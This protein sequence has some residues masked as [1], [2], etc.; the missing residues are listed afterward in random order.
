[1]KARVLI[2]DDSPTVRSTLEWLL[3]D[4]GYMVAVAQD[5]LEALVLLRDYRPELVLLDIFLPFV[6]GIQICHFIRQ[7]PE[8]ASVPVIMISGQAS[9]SEVEK[10]VTAGANGYLLKPVQDAAL[11]QILEKYLAHSGTPGVGSMGGQP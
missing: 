2:V 9:K 11:L 3:C 8:I 5:G 4:Q 10:A 1:V 7:Q 6:D